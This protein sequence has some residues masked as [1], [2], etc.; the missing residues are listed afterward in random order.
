MIE[1]GWAATEILDVT[2][3]HDVKDREPAA[4]YAPQAFCEKDQNR[5]GVLP[6]IQTSDQQIVFWNRIAASDSTKIR[7]SWHKRADDGWKLMAHVDLPILK[8]SSFRI[9]STKD[10]HPTFHR[11][12]WMIVVTLSDDPKKVLCI[13]RFI[14]E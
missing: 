1:V 3:A 2:L 5:N 14:V 8:S 11:G 10:L 6:R 12:E 7:H 13:T 4:P 9:W